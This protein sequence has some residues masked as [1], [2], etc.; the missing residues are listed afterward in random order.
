[1]TIEEVFAS[2]NERAN[3]QVARIDKVMA[4]NKS[5]TELFVAKTNAWRESVG[6]EPIAMPDMTGSH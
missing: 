1:M 4:D 5:A 3:A 6:I 2:I